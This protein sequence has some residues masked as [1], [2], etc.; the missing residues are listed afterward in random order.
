M[1]A[2]GL[3]SESLLFA[4]LLISCKVHKFIESQVFD[5]YFGMGV[6][7]LDENDKICHFLLLNTSPSFLFVTGQ[8]NKLKDTKMWHRTT[9]SNSL[10]E[11]NCRKL[12]NASQLVTSLSAKKPKNAKLT[13]RTAVSLVISWW[14]YFSCFVMLSIPSIFIDRLFN[15][16]PQM[17]LTHFI[18]VKAFAVNL[19]LSWW[20]LTPATPYCPLKD[21]LLWLHRHTCK[22]THTSIWQLL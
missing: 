4:L 9:G 17:G 5:V 1:S 22:R 19:H 20:P 11:L 18:T 10:V 7:S 8:N 13:N 15:T 12:C 2:L 16:L 21:L 6:R 3:P 14:V